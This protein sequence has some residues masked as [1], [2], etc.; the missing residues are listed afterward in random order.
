[1][2]CNG[3]LKS[4]KAEGPYSIL[5]CNEGQEFYVEGGWPTETE[6]HAKA[7]GLVMSLREIRWKATITA[8]IEDAKGQ[9]VSEV[10]D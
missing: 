1:M 5:V 9:V 7:V 8:R 2:G 3:V 10:G 4:S 6:A